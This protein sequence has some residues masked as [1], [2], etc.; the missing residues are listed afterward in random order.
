MAWSSLLLSFASDER[1]AADDDGETVT[2]DL[3]GVIVGD[4]VGFMVVGSSV[5]K[6]VG[7][8]VGATVVGVCVEEGRL[9]G[10]ATGE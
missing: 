2:N 3:V 7:A 4:T 10:D 8:L 5:G 9:T 6:S 1:F